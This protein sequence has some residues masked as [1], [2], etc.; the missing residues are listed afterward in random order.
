MTAAAVGLSTEPIPL[1][2]ERPET[3]FGDLDERQRSREISDVMRRLNRYK[4]INCQC[5]AK[6]RIP[7]KFKESTVM[8]PHCGRIHSV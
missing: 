1:L 5:G 7:P 3:K 2:T 6:L 4:E 8:C